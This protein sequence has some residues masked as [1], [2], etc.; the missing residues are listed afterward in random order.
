LQIKDLA[1]LL[2][3]LLELK[4]VSKPVILL[5]QKLIGDLEV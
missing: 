1:L 5:S 2:V 3:L 4:R